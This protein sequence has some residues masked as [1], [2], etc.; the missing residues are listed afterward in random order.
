MQQCGQSDNSAEDDSVVSSTDSEDG[1]DD[2]YNNNYD[3]NSDQDS[4]YIPEKDT[5]SYSSSAFT[6]NPAEQ[7]PHTLLNGPQWQLANPEARRAAKVDYRL[8]KPGKPKTTSTAKKQER[9]SNVSS[10]LIVLHLRQSYGAPVMFQTSCCLAHADN[11]R[12]VQPTVVE[13]CPLFM[14]LRPVQLRKIEQSVFFL[15]LR[16]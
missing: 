16:L 2:T 6:T 13:R 3:D 7:T 11:C 8:K 9:K 4:D 1:D 10:F 12:K 5:P 15:T 14:T